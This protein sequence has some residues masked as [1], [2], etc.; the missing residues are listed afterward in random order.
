M[1]GERSCDGGVD[2][3]VCW[4][5]FKGCVCVSV[6]PCDRERSSDV[7]FKSR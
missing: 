6:N 7:A 5:R 2:Q 3:L 1:S 4:R